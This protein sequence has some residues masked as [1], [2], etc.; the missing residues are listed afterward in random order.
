MGTREVRSMEIKSCRR[1]GAIFQY[2]TGKPICP[3]CRKKEEELFQ[4]VKSFLREN[5]G[6]NMAQ[7]SEATGAP[8]PMIESFLREGRI[9]VTPD[10]PLGI[11]CERCGAMI[12]TGKYCDKC[13]NEVA[14]DLDGMARAMREDSKQETVKQ[15]E[16]ERMRFLKSDKIR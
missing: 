13:R 5:P 4:E 2:V 1:C 16:K 11:S 6:S 8:I 12:R 9:E 15:S 10:S 7:I 14:S 3:R